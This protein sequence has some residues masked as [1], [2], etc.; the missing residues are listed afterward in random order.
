MSLMLFLLPSVFGII[1][2]IVYNNICQKQ[3]QTF[4]KDAPNLVSAEDEKLIK[5]ARAKLEKYV[6][7]ITSNS[8]YEEQVKAISSV[9]TTNILNVEDLL[10]NNAGKLF[11]LHREVGAEFEGGL[12]VRMTV[13]FNLFAGCVANLGNDSQREWLDGSLKRGELGCFALTE[14]GAGVLSGLIVETICQWTDK[15]YVLNSPTI[16][17]HKTWISQ[18]ITAKWCIVIARLILKDKTD[19]GP[20]AFIVD[21]QSKGIVLKDMVQKADFNG[22]DN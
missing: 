7:N 10:I 11:L 14:K 3:K 1:I 4:L 5:E 21:L 9:L 15:G 17:S 13:Q 8:T 16:K 2:F 12:G 20:H 22:L 19:K 6:M 18:G